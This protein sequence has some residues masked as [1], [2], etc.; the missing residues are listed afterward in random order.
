MASRGGSEDEV[1][2][3]AILRALLPWGFFI[4]GGRLI[5]NV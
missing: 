2:Q 3:G 4:F 5:E 1:K